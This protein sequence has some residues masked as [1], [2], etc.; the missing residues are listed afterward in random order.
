[1]GEKK[2][3]FLIGEPINLQERF[4]LCD[5]SVEIHKSATPVIHQTQAKTHYREV[6]QVQIWMNPQPKT[7][8]EKEDAFVLRQSVIQNIREIVQANRKAVPDIRFM[9]RGG[10]VHLD[11]APYLQTIMNVHCSYS[12]P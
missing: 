1:M 7:D 9:Y 4:Y 5:I 3:R 10:E 2:I 12:Y 6:L 8:A 11:P